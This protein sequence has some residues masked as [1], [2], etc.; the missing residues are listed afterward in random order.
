[1]TT[2]GNIIDNI[3]TAGVGEVVGNIVDGDIAAVRADVNST[4]GADELVVGVGDEG[5]ADAG[6]VGRVTDWVGGVG[7]V[8]GNM[9]TAGDS[10]NIVTAGVDGV[11]GNTVDGDTAAVGAGAG[12]LVGVGDENAVDAGAVGTVTTMCSSLVS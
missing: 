8:D 7:D 9:T 1:M 12:G 3:I 4:S 10:F 5:A 11:V 2:A 6:A